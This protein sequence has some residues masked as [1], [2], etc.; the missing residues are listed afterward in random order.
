M[1]L[2]TGRAFGAAAARAPSRRS[3]RGAGV[4][5]T[6]AARAVAASRSSPHRRPRAPTTHRALA[7]SSQAPA[8]AF[9]EAEDR[10]IRLA[11]TLNAYEHLAFTSKSTNMATY[12]YEQLALVPEEHRV[13]LMDELTDRGLVNCWFIAGLLY[14][15]KLAE[16]EATGA[17]D[18]STDLEE[19]QERLERVAER[20]EAPGGC[21]SDDDADEDDPDEYRR[22][23][24]SSSTSAS[25]S[26]SA[27]SSASSASAVLAARAGVQVF[28]GR[29]ANVPGGPL[30]DRFQ[31]VFYPSPTDPG[32]WHG[33]VCV[34]KPRAI[35]RFLPLYF[36]TNDT[37]E[38]FLKVP[39]TGEDADL[40]LDYENPPY[41]EADM[42]PAM[43]R[44]GRMTPGAGT[45]AT[46]W[47]VPKLPPP[48]F[49]TLVDY[50]RPLGPGVYAGRGGRG[51]GR[52]EEFLTFILFRRYDVVASEDEEGA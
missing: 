21:V 50:L 52:G 18:I 16:R 5:S 24:G 44:P 17:M 8:D 20:F 22:D 12:V 43:S 13:L 28:E 40:M 42:P 26:D 49:D 2:A 41:L 32:T 35:E 39:A 10:I 4:P 38:R 47:P 34:K 29:A 31:K 25:A 51:G 7:P 19:Y 3:P 33:R 11:T 9:E 23:E 36:R 14:K 46:W 1:S 30:I 27:S 48:P 6:S 15:V 45:L 37:L